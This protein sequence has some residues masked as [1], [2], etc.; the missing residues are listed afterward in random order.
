MRTPLSRVSR[1]GRVTMVV[2]GILLV[3]IAI[4]DRI[5]DLWADW[6]WFTEVRY[7][8][9]FSGM[10]T[11]RLLLLA[12][13]G[14]GVGLIVAL[15]LYLAYRM[16][17]LLRPHSAEQHALDRYRMLL[18]PRMGMWIGILAGLVGLFAG[19]SAQGRWQQWLLFA[20]S[21][22]FG[23]ADPQFKVDIGFYV[24]EYPFYR[25]LLGVGFGAVVIALIGVLG[26]HYLFG[27][28]R[29]Q[30]AGDRMTPAARAH[31]TALV[32]AFVLLKSAAYFLDRRGLLLGSNPSVKDLHGASYTAVNA[33]LPA[34]EIL[35]WIS[36]LVALAILVFSNAFVRNLVWPG[37]AL[38]L[39]GISAVV[40]GGIIPAGV[41]SFTVKP[42]PFAKESKYIKL[43][44]DATRQAYGLAGVRT[45]QYPANVTSPPPELLTD[46]V[47]VPNVRLLD[48]AVVNDTYTQLQQVRGF[49]EFAE[50]LDIDRYNV[51]GVT[52]DYVVG[53]REINYSELS[54]TQSN[55]QNKHTVFTHG[56]GFVAAPAN[57]LVCDGQ[58][59]FVSGFLADRSAS[60]DRCTDST[61][62][63]PASQP[64]IYYGERM[65]D[66][67]AVVGKTS[68]GDAEFDRPSGVTDQYFT[69]DGKGGVPIGSYGRRV[70]YSFHLRETNF[71]LSS[72]FN[73]DSK[74]MYVRE[75][76]K[77][78]EKI[79][80]FLTIDGD[81]Y[82][83][84]LGGRIVWILD[85]Y[86]TASTYP[87]ST[88]VDLKSATTD[89][90]TGE[91][92]FAQQRQDINYLRN[93]VKATVDAYDGT[94]TLYS[95]DDEDPVL[96]TWNKAFGG[97]LVRPSSEIPKELQEHLRYP[98]DQ[99]KVQRDLLSRFHVTAPNEFFSQQDFWQVPGDPASDGKGKQPPY[100]LLAKL[101]NQDAPTF[102][103]TAAMVPRIRANLAA[104]VSAY[105]VSGKPVLQV[106]ELPDNTNILGP[107]QIHQK[108]TN[109]DDT[110]RREINQFEIGGSQLVYGNLLSLP[111]A[112][113]MLYVQPLYIQSTQANNYPLMKK[114]LINYGD[115]SAYADN[116]QQGIQQLI[117]KAS[118]KTP[119]VGQGNQQQGNP[120]SST[121]GGLADAVARLQNAIN[122]Y[123]AATQSGDFE[124]IGKALKA[125]DEAIKGFEEA[126]KA[127]GT[128]GG[129]PGA[130]PSTGPSPGPSGSPAPGP[131]PSRS[132]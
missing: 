27:G 51:D 81:P 65:G 100:Y 16:R 6:L 63:I 77:R 89:T 45:E 119:A 102:Q 20:N 11:T 72:V 2:L 46:K 64:R 70:L 32:A 8:R 53:V 67:Y 50:K 34:K 132:G 1:R 52:Q 9:V 95:F 80:P 68:G 55:W 101:P 39:L 108:M 117:E 88:R 118:G 124:R 107:V 76:R 93:S 23:V 105:Y 18:L 33:L 42:S 120:N 78:V 25:Y 37:V 123:R 79:A 126:K 61:D 104:L 71:L 103:L 60:T 7:T 57:T 29:L 106:Y 116:M 19:I 13:F 92:T 127:A 38:A 112:G 96:R 83:A 35:A 15:N 82:P 130:S 90:Q 3:L 43:S 14:I 94:V 58:P 111:L 4:A 31:L 91:G 36:L 73:K 125:L 22:P 85:G 21:E 30:G 110:A 115:Y 114:V 113:G 49:Y 54:G 66:A 99:F 74:L 75:P 59:K 62:K 12:T 69:Y 97:K 26:L 122:E 24:F 86:T 44:I 129:A 121:D 28:V 47:T 98:E 84:V 56:Y 87:Y 128:A 17:P 10:L 131:S 109:Q 48:P 41:Q 40:I 5:I